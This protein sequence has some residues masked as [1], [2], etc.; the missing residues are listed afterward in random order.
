MNCHEVKNHLFA[1]SDGALNATE[2]AALDA[3]CATCA[4]CRRTR[5]DLAA[6]LTTWRAESA[7]APLPDVE[8]EWHA[9]RRKIRGGLE[10]G[11]TVTLERPRRLFTWIAV[12]VMAAAAA[13]LTFY[14]GS[15][16]EREA[17]LASTSPS[18]TPQIARAD[19]VE[20]PGKASTTV[21]VD[22]KS[23]WLVVWAT[24]PKEI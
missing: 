22:E 7:R 19:S 11:S 8:R 4:D 3:H 2:R 15:G 13:A 6:A 12:P 24:D 1:G 16:S 23:G 10:A 9:V 18:T 17:T 20:V 5:D 14:M 21:Y